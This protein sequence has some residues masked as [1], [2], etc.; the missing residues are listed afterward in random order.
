MK[1]DISTDFL[2][3]Y[4]KKILRTNEIDLSAE[5]FIY[6]GNYLSVCPSTSQKQLPMSF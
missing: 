6:S 5:H 3:Y 1:E 2:E 4:F